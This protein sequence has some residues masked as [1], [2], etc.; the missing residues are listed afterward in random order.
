MITMKN[1]SLIIAVTLL[2][3]QVALYSISCS[4]GGHRH[5][6]VSAGEY[7]SEDELD[8]LS[9][10]QRS[11][12]CN[13]L[14]NE[15]AASQREFEAKTTELQ[16]TK[17]LIQSIRRQIVPVEQEVLKLE[18][19]IRSVNDE[20]AEVKALPQT[21]KIKPGDSLTYIA[22]QPNVYNDLDKWERIFEANR[23]KILDPYY[24]FPDTVLVIPRDWPTD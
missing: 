21:W 23:D 14:N 18:S 8:A 3:A 6:K 15:M 4:G 22:M 17:D 24:I 1:L 10:G 7:Y 13:D 12:Y 9:A 11:K 16:E 20:I 2:I 19:D 5:V